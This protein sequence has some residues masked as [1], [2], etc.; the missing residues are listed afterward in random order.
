MFFSV[1]ETHWLFFGSKLSLS[2]FRLLEI[3]QFQMA[4]FSVLFFG[5]GQEHGNV[6]RENLL[7]FHLSLPGVERKSMCQLSLHLD[8][9][10]K[11]N[12]IHI[13]CMFANDKGNIELK[14]SLVDLSLLTVKG[15][16]S[17]VSLSTR[18]TTRLTD[19]N[20]QRKFHKIVTYQ[21]NK[22]THTHKE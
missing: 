2:E 4:A 1:A 10:Q 7:W 9:H 5:C 19:S 8:Q 13:S 21:L 18:L 6:L 22:E 14:A 16:P 3:W 20:V 17:P 12:V 15:L 11:W